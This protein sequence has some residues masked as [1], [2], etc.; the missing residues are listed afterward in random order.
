MTSLF[1]CLVEPPSVPCNL[2]LITQNNSITVNWLSPTETGGRSD[3]YY[4]VEYSDP[5]ILGS[6]IGTVYL[7]GESTNHTF[8]NLRPYIS[9]CIQVS[10]HNGVSDQDPERSQISL[11]EKCT[12]TLEGK[13]VFSELF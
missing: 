13:C 4:Q 10:A 2:R 6:F 8:T 11:I 9:Y 1:I 12:H 3:L 7:D 5:D